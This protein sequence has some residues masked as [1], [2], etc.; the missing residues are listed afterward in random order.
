MEANRAAVII[1]TYWRCYKANKEYNK[2]VMEIS[3]ST[4]FNVQFSEA[5]SSEVVAVSEEE[6]SE[7]A[8][9]KLKNLCKQAVEKFPQE[10]QEAAQRIANGTRI[11]PKPEW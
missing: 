2:Q 10:M 7:K 11:S 4:I 9:E 6:L 5:V 8:I 3:G 1:Q